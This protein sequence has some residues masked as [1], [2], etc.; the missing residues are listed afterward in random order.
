MWEA[1]TFKKMARQ[2]SVL[3]SR[4]PLAKAARVSSDAQFV[5]KQRPQNF[6]SQRDNITLPFSI[7]HT[8]IARI[9]FVSG[10]ERAKS[11]VASRSRCDWR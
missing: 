11:R 8:T 4:A 1:A 6:E 2:G 7:E 9:G 5:T 10:L 3:G